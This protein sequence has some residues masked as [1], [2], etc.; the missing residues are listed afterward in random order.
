MAPQALSGSHFRKYFT[1]FQHKC[2]P[3]W[4]GLVKRHA[5][6]HQHPYHAQSLSQQI[7]SHSKSAARWNSPGQIYIAST[8]L[9]CPCRYTFTSQRNDWQRFSPAFL[10]SFLQ[11]FFFT[12]PSYELF[13]CLP[14][15]RTLFPEWPQLLFQPPL[16]FF[17]YPY[18]NFFFPRFTLR[19]F[20]STFSLL[21]RDCISSLPLLIFM[22]FLAVVY[23]LI[24]ST[25]F[26]ISSLTH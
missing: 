25:I 7:L 6:S 16:R 2:Q 14:Q 9:G 26:S 1:A 18:N 3:E 22:S 23:Q 8:T 20:F 11:L 13:S 4:I 21:N 12:V 10:H 19:C 15:L 5:S 17:H 24:E